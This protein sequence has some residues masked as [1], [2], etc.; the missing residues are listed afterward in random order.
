MRLSEQLTT[1]IGFSPLVRLDLGDYQ[2]E[3]E[4]EF[5]RSDDEVDAWTRTMGVVVAVDRP[6]D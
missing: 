1:L 6:Y 2:T 5:V 3:W 4:A